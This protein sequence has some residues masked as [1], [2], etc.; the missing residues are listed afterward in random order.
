MKMQTA[1]MRPAAESDQTQLRAAIAVDKYDPVANDAIEEVL[2]KVNGAPS[3]A[4][5]LVLKSN[6]I[7]RVGTRV[8]KDETTG[9]KRRSFIAPPPRSL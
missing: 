4:R 5:R 2:G 1:R 7:T 3:K 6:Q 9:K 8:V